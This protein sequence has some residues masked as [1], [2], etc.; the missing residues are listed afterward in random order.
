MDNKAIELAKQAKREYQKKYR[1][2]NKEK[3]SEYNKA[4]QKKYQQSEKGKAAK[5]RYWYKKAIES[6]LVENEKI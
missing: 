3:I 4:Y 1:E 6:G 5:I 2:T